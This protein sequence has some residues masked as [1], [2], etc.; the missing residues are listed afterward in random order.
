MAEE[1]KT[2]RV[3]GQQ[4]S[5]MHQVEQSKLET[6]YSRLNVA[7]KVLVDQ[8][9][10]IDALKEL[11]KEKSAIIL[12]PL[13]AGTYVEAKIENAEK[14]KS[15][16]SNGVMVD[17]EISKTL[18]KL[19]QLLEKTRKEVE[20]LQAEQGIAYNNLAGIENIIAFASKQ[21][22]QKGKE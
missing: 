16:V 8:L 13:G 19:E 5:E 1:G 2:V 10:A 7:Q 14:V 17:T 11:Q 12:V 22:Q 20:M 9:A 4:L 18:K 15:S 3:S 21:M 6:L